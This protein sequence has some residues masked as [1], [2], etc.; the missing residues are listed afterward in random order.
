MAR[1]KV[2]VTTAGIGDWRTPVRVDDDLSRAAY[3]A[4][5][6]TRVVFEDG[7]TVHLKTRFVGIDDVTEDGAVPAG[8]GIVEAQDADGDWL[9][10]RIDWFIED[11]VDRG[12]YT[13]S[14]GTGKWKEVDGTVDVVLFALPEDLE[15]EMPP[16]TP[17]RF[18]GFFEGEGELSV[19]NLAAPGDAA[20][21]KPTWWTR[22]ARG[23]RA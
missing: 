10:G 13:F 2:L 22:E 20:I 7:P 4:H 23:V 12:T 1:Q 3:E 17:I 16:R 15:A 8:F 9:R 5:L 18:Y 14:S 19:P 21:S 11:G 6:C